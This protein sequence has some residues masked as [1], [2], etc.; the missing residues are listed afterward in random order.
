[1]AM[2]PM[3]ALERSELEEDMNMYAKRSRS[4]LPPWENA[5]LPDPPSF[6]LRNTL[7]LIG[8]GA[9][10][11]GIS[12]GSGEWLIGPA[13][14][15]QFGGGLLW[16]ALV[17][18]IFQVFMNMEFIRYTMYTG[19]PIYTGFMRTKPGAAFWSIFYGVLAFLQLGWPGWAF[20]AATAVVAAVIGRVPSDGDAG[21]VQLFGFLCFV[22]TVII[23]ASGSK[24]ERT[25]ELVQWFFVIA[26][27]SFLFVIG[28][29]CTSADTW[30]KVG[31]GFVSFGKFPERI[32]WVLIGAF[33]AYAGAGGVI[34]GTI[35]N[36]FRD[37]GFGMGGTVGY[38]PALVGGKKLS[39]SPVGKIF[40]LTPTNLER[41]KRWWKFAKLDQYGVWALGCIIGMGLPAL[42][43]IEFIPPGTKLTGF[44]AAAIQA[45][46]LAEIWGNAMWFITLL[47]GFWVLYSTQLGITDC[48]VRM[49]T[50]IVWTGSSRA[51]E[52]CKGDIRLVYYFVLTLFT[53][54]GIFILFSGLKPLFL[55]LLG[56]NI[57]GLN[58]VFL[59]L[60][61]LYVNHRLL[62]RPLRPGRFQTLMVILGTVFFGFFFVNALPVMVKQLF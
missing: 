33:A 56:A 35:S 17:S 59:G 47:V 18:I 29:I 30:I 45:Q 50:D 22:S 31:K 51:R 55:I 19:E 14:T 60:H 8:P 43:T 41:F 36:W 4:E 5:D 16:V 3:N 9:I 58:F 49:T 34:N 27:F 6:T 15:A 54:W 24:I 53:L 61:T 1:M 25:M 28:A 37:K 46:Y 13:V 48:F 52:M 12:I 23:V 62:P 39:L 21:M 26:I 38:I 57:A 7:A 11:L 10:L 42:L 40:P 44:G 32:D 2:V 20:S